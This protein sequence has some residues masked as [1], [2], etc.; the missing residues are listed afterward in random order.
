MELESH[1]QMETPGPPELAFPSL[2][3]P[4]L[5]KPSGKLGASA[6]AK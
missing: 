5:E 4:A 1:S 3:Y 2:P 6:N